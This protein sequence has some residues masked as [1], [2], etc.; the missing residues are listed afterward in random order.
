MIEVP[1]SP[2]AQGSPEE[3]PSTQSTRR[4][5]SCVRLPSLPSMP[6]FS[7]KNYSEMSTP[8]A[9]FPNLLGRQV[10]FECGSPEKCGEKSAKSTRRQKSPRASSQT[11][12]GTGNQEERRRHRRCR[13]IAPEACQQLTPTTPEND[14]GDF[15]QD[16]SPAAQPR[17]VR[18]QRRSKTTITQHH[19]SLGTASSPSNKGLQLDAIPILSAQWRKGAQIGQGSYGRVHKAQDRITGQIFAVKEAVVENGSEDDRQYLERLE[20]ELSICRELRHPNIVSCYGHEHVADRLC[21]FL[22]YVPGGSMAGVLKEFGALNGKLLQSAV[23]GSLDGLHYLHTHSPPVVHRDIKGANLLVDLKF[24]VKLAD[25][26]CSK[27]NHETRSFKVIGSVP[28]M[29]PEVIL[30]H[31]G[32]GRKA[33]IWSL[34]CMVLEMATATQ[35]WGSGAFDNLWAAIRRIGMTQDVPP[36]PED[37]SDVCQDFVCS[38]VQRLVEQRPT[39]EQLLDHEFLLP[40]SVSSSSR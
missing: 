11:R 10:L 18:R 12:T 39:A 29:A 38:C 6:S 27:R 2:A 19:P 23:Q 4:S 25:F 1:V 34:G 28:W 26:G 40:A 21:I 13:T 37:L 17:L 22:E 7:Q 35:P 32:Y 14:K 24:H 3:T 20:E 33:D 8:P 16:P 31:V 5:L 9:A 30:G 36:I 15:Q